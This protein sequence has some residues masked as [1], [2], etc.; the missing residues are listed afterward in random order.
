MPAPKGKEKFTLWLY[1]ETL[2][3]VTEISRFERSYK[4]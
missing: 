3:K 2:K 4:F 1:P